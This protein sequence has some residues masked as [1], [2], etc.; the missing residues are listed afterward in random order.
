MKKF[1]IILLFLPILFWLASCAKCEVLT[2]QHGQEFETLYKENTM[3]G[4]VDYLKVLDYSDTSARIY[5]VGINRSDGNTVK[6][7]KQKGQW[8]CEEWETV[9]SKTGSA[10]GFVWPYIR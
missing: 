10:D 2:Y 5:Y 4:E 1:L 6:Y 7:V 8:V 9:W 3:I